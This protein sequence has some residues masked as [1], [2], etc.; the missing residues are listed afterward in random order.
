MAH[1][2]SL[3]A[4]ILV[5][6]CRGAPDAQLIRIGHSMA[7]GLARE[8]RCYAGLCRLRARVAGLSHVAT[9]VE[10][11]LCKS[12]RYSFASKCS[13]KKAR[14]RPRIDSGSKWY[15]IP[16]ISKTSPVTAPNPFSLT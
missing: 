1:R 7:F 8:A 11:A 10:R 14:Q 6:L 15:R 16:G 3:A 9:A 2:Q 13:A 4:A 5:R 12:G